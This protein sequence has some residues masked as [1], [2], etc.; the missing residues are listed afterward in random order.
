M[1]RVAVIVHRLNLAESDGI[2][3]YLAAFILVIFVVTLA[4]FP[5][6]LGLIYFKVHAATVV[7]TGWISVNL[8]LATLATVVILYDWLAVFQF[9]AF[10]L[11]YVNS[12]CRVLRKMT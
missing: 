10:A 1:Y 9:I 3:L 11:V 12:N 6:S 2:E 4:V 7:H 8:L 5:V